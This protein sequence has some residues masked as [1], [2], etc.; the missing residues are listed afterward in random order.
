LD[1]HYEK[2]GENDMP[3]LKQK[4]S[5]MVRDAQLY[6]SLESG[7]GLLAPT[8]DYVG[9]EHFIKLSAASCTIAPPASTA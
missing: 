2:R 9:A 8:V 6:F 7:E 5:R 1:E 4:P 3:L